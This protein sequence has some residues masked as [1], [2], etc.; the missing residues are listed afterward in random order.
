MYS[1]ILKMIDNSIFSSLIPTFIE[2]G[3]SESFTQN[4][5]FPQ[6]RIGEYGL[7]VRDNPQFIYEFRKLPIHD[8][9]NLIKGVAIIEHVILGE[10][11]AGSTTPV[12]RLFEKLSE[13][14][15]KELDQKML[16]ELRLWLELNTTN[17]FN[18][19]P[20]Q[21]KTKTQY[22]EFKKAELIRIIEISKRHK[23]QREAKK[24]RI[25]VK[26]ENH[27]AK[28][29]KSKK[30]S[31]ERAEII[32]KMKSLSSFERLMNIASSKR[33]INFY[34]ASLVDIDRSDIKRLSNQ[35]RSLLF[36][37]LKFVRRRTGW[38]RLKKLL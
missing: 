9:L 26:A 32:E 30:L 34:P 19:S 4:D 38:R 33:N 10:G 11:G 29:Q 15:Q 27:R 13:W 16:D 36:E 35:I 25:K 18:K 22:D 8:A 14:H 12:Y 3:K 17:Y 5:N 21:V 7:M 23:E 28:V 2:T 20:N 37:K 31:L 24:L 1:N 6:I